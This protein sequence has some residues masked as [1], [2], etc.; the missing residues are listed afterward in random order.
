MR[1]CAA[2]RLKRALPVSIG[3]AI[4]VGGR[5][6]ELRRESCRSMRF[7]IVGPLLAFEVYYAQV[8]STSFYNYR[9]DLLCAFVH[10]SLFI[11]IH[12]HV[13]AIYPGFLSKIHEKR[14]LPECYF[15]QSRPRSDAT[16]RSG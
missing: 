8:Y 15:L 7:A 16:K 11:F 5:V 2:R 6:L 12:F 14:N 13:D 4:E 9:A 10:S 1:T 3:A